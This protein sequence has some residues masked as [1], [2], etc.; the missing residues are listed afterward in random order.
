MAK[1]SSPHTASPQARWVRGGGWAP[2]GGG[3]FRPRDPGPP[4]GPGFGFHICFGGTQTIPHEP[5]VDLLKARELTHFLGDFE[6]I[7]LEDTCGAA[8]LNLVWCQQPSF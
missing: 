2:F 6:N 7:I 3:G 1:L 5:V 4:K 8:I